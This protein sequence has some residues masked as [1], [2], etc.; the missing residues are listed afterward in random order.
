MMDGWLVMIVGLSRPVSESTGP[1]QRGPVCPNGSKS[2]TKANGVNHYA[3]GFGKPWLQVI[4]RLPT[5]SFSR[6][7]SSSLVSWEIPNCTLCCGTW[8]PMNDKHYASHL[9]AQGGAWA[10]SWK[11]WNQQQTW[12]ERILV[13]RAGAGKRA[14]KHTTNTKKKFNETHLIVSADWSCCTNCRWINE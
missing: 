13:I 10:L 8:I 7:R 9:H 12:T 3:N 14:T 4:G 11:I 1:A 2:K 6:C 5:K